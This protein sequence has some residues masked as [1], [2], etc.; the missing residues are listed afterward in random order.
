MKTIGA[1]VLGACIVLSA[2]CVPAKK[3]PV[4]SRP[5]KAPLTS[6]QK[7][8][9]DKLYYHGVE[10]YVQGELKAA[11]ATWKKV[12]EKDPGHVDARRSLTRTAQ[13]LSALKKRGK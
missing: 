7:A 6:A 2:A 3:A 4:H 13:E 8:E 9:C 12:L 10:Q 11:M 5:A 1:G